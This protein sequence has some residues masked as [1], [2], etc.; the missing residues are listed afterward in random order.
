VEC[1]KKTYSYPR[2]FASEIGFRDQKNRGRVA[3]SYSRKDYPRL[4]SIGCYGHRSGNHGTGRESPTL[5]GGLVEAQDVGGAALALQ[6][7]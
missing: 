1:N 4:N 6:L 5:I 3:L 2:P 7:F